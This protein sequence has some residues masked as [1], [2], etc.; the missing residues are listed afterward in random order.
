[1]S[2]VGPC[3]EIRGKRETDHL[4]DEGLI[5]SAYQDVGKQG[6]DFY[7][8]GVPDVTQGFVSSLLRQSVR[9]RSQYAD[10]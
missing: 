3:M 8:T 5:P 10:L 4:S 7:S 9:T 2:G 1:M 6:L